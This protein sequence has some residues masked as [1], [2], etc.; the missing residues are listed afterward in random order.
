MAQSRQKSYAD[1]RCHELSFE[2]NDFVYLNVSP[3]KSH[4]R[5]NVKGKIAPRYIRLYRIIEKKGAM[6]YKLDLPAA[7]EGVH[8]VFH[9]SQLKKCLRILIEEAPLEG[10]ESPRDLTCNA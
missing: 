3:L 10:Y 5:F 4:Q 8:N 6:A 9:V 1:H 7:L 2:P